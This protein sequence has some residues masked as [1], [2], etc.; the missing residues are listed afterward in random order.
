MRQIA[1]YVKYIIADRSVQLLVGFREP[2]YC[3]LGQ[4][5]QSPFSARY[6]DAW[7]NRC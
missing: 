7:L 1:R 5:G 3:E 6:P 4:S 2:T